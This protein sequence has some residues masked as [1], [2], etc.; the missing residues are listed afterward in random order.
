MKKLVVI[1][2][3]NGVGKSTTAKRIVNIYDGCAYIDSDW[4]RVM[5]PFELTDT[6]KQTVIENIYCLIRNYLLCD[7]INTVVFTYSWHGERK[8][9]YEAVI[10][11]LLDDGIKFEEKIIILKCSFTENIRRAKED[12]RDEER[13][14][15]GMEKT[16]NFYDVFK[17]PCIDTSLMNPTEIAEQIIRMI[18]VDEE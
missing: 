7:K 9:I 8:Y 4:C 6:S 10:N 18:E 3:P 17:Y 12:G 1:I 5:N 16:F 15:R 2:G 11:K 13:V 14:N